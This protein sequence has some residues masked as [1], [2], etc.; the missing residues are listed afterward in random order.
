MKHV[1]ATIRNMSNERIYLGNINVDPVNG[2]PLNAGCDI[3]YCST[4][5]SGK[6]Y[7]CT[8]NDKTADVRMLEVV[9]EG[10]TCP[11]NGEKLDFNFFVD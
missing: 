10:D 2:R 4:C 7:L 1:I 9:S 8:D 11:M 3:T 5:Y 6:I